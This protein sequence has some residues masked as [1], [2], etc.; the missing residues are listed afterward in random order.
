M[1]KTSLIKAIVQMCDDIVH[2][3]PLCT[4]SPSA[5]QTYKK[6]SKSKFRK[7]SPDISSTSHIAEIYASTRAY[8]HW[9][10]EIDEGKLLRRR[11][12][13]GDTVLER[14]ICFVDTPGYSN[15]TSVSSMGSRGPFEL[16]DKYSFWRRSHPLFNM[17]KPRLNGR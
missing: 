1:G 16:T 4:P 10:S 5:V 13:T 7:G 6:N 8:P 14:N 2:V 15:G 11:K 3:D 12:S 9:W 17:S